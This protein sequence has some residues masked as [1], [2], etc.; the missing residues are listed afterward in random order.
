MKNILSALLTVIIAFSLVVASLSATEASL[1]CSA[2]KS[3]LLPGEEV[4]LT[5]SLHN[6]PNAK[7]FALMFSYES[8]DLIDGGW[9]L[10]DAL[11]SDFDKSKNAAVIAFIAETDINGDVFT[12]RLKLKDNVSSGPVTVTVTPTIKNGETDI[13]CDSAS[14]SLTVSSDTTSSVCDHS[15][16]AVDARASTCA[17]QGWDAYCYCVKCGQLFASDSVT[18]ISSVPLLPFA[19]HSGG[20]ATCSQPAVCSVCGQSYGS[21]DPANHVGQTEVRNRVEPTCTENGYSGDTYCLSCNQLISAGT[22]I[23]A[24]GHDY[25][26]TVTPPT[27]SGQGY[28]THICSRCGDTYKSDYTNAEE[29]CEHNL[30]YVDGVEATCETDGQSP[31]WLCDRCGKLFGDKDGQNEITAE[32]IVIKATDHVWGDWAVT[33]AATETEEGEESRSCSKCGKTETRSVSVSEHMHTLIKTEA[34]SATCTKNGNIEYY[35]CSECGK[36]FSD[37][38]GTNEI[39]EKDTV[40]S[41][42]GHDW[43]EW[44]VTRE[45][46]ETAEGEE[47]RV[48]GRDVAHTE[49]RSIPVQGHVHGMIAVSPTSPTC[50]TPGNIEYWICSS[51]GKF[52]SDPNGNSEIT[53]ESTVISAL[54]HEWGEWITT[55][56]PQPDEKGQATRT[57]LRDGSHTET[58]EL[59]ALPDNDENIKDEPSENH[60]E[61]QPGSDSNNNGYVLWIVIAIVAVIAVIVTI[62]LLKRKKPKN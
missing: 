22:V 25:Q 35:K 9:L 36:L 44:T 24:L 12:L 53:H 18:E 47:T 48:C 13:H 45:A 60:E 20:T 28:T 50:E 61:T 23:N 10:S 38:E 2:S 56:E 49:K 15:F 42:L 6:A 39:N 32:S 41:S 5:V 54:G 11:L 4:T 17:E 55:K 59:D 27:D 16:V 34:K 3:V 8:F 30:Q 7:S 19:P 40:V 21:V 58:K 62:L 14:L 29:G 43:G 33:K 26:D 51:C 52:Y 57:C 31:Y 37:A 1:T 46:T